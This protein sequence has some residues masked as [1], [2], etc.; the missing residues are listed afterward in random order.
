VTLFHP[1]NLPVGGMRWTRTREPGIAL[2]AAAA[3]ARARARANALFPG[4]PARSSFPVARPGERVSSVNDVQCA[5][6]VHTCGHLL[7]SSLLPLNSTD[8]WHRAP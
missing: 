4:P 7:V 1:F 6:L 8:G 5:L 2:A 3:E